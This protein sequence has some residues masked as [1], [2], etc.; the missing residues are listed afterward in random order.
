MKAPPGTKPLAILLAAAI[1]GA[2]A[3]R[4]FADRLPPVP[5][6]PLR[7]G[8]EPNP[9]FQIRTQQGFSGLVVDTV[10]EAARR[11]GLHLEWVDT[12]TN[13]EESFQRGLV[14]LWPSM[15][16]TV[17]QRKKGYLSAPW[18]LASHILMTTAGSRPL[19]SGFSGRI[20]VFK[21]PVHTHLVHERFPDA[22]VF[23]FPD[24][25][26]VVKAVCTGR[27]AAGLLEKRAA[28]TALLSAPAECASKNL[29]IHSLPELAVKSCLASTFE[30]AGAAA[31]LRREIGN[32][33][34][35]GS[36]GFTMAR[37]SFYGL[38]D[39]W[40]TFD[41]MQATERFRWMAWGSAAFAVA[42]C[43]ALWQTLLLRQRRRSERELRE[44][45][46]RFRAIFQQAGVGVAQVNLDG[47]VELAND[48]YCAVVGHG[49]GTLLGKGTRE[50]TVREDL[51]E[52]LAM[53][54]K[55]LSG[56]IQSFSTQKRYEREDGTLVWAELCKSL[57]RNLDG[58]PKHFIAVVQDI[59]ERKQAEAA[60]KESEERFRNMA[61][62]AP[63]L[64]W[65]AAP[66]QQRTFF[67]KRWLEFTG[68]PMEEDLGEG[69]TAL[70]HPD[71]LA[72]YLA[73]YASSFTTHRDFQMEYRLRRADGEYRFMLVHGVARLSKDG[74]FAG[75]IGSCIDITD[76]KSN[77]ER[78]LAT[79]KLESLGVL[80]AGVAH[81]FNNLLG[82]IV[83]RSECATGEL[84][85][86]SAAADD[87]EQIRV[88]AL[89]AAEI[90]SQMMT[91]AGQ[92]NAPL[93]PIDLSNLVTETLA[94]LRVSIAKGAVLKTELATNLPRV[95]ANSAE[96][97]QVVM[98]LIINAS[99]A[100]EGKPG[101]ISIAT[102]AASSDAG[103]AGAVRLRVEDTGC[104]MTD[105]VKTRIFDPFFTTRFAGRGLGLAAVQG[106]VRR[107]G[108]W[109]DVESEPGRG[110][111]FTVEL[112][113]GTGQ[114]D[115]STQPA[116]P[117]ASA[118]PA[119]SAVLFVDDEDA[120][121]T[122]V[123][124]VLRR[125]GFEVIEAADGASAIEILR[126]NQAAIGRI[127]LD[128]TL[129]GISGPE[130]FDELR[131][132][133][134]DVRIIV[135]TAYSQETVLAT[136]PGRNL[137]DF[138]R[139]PYRTHELVKLLE[140]TTINHTEPH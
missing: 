36:L 98:N 19:E 64:I 131:R 38:D 17:E 55:L 75:Y 59:T 110:S 31:R 115:G 54:P 81:D 41:L 138:I 78:H 69:W 7:I 49:R 65:V 1:A 111:R 6:R 35:D 95:D 40:A 94:L 91:F 43:I 123:S 127:V 13:S 30:A 121:R 97:R 3:Y 53:M 10:N 12:G 132:M 84:A 102:Y 24:A 80:A 29:R 2:A 129:P 73:T 58:E 68:R 34:R 67:N 83:A 85:P 28:T 79:Q 133:S 134:P 50:M 76:L 101:C 135:S 112:P 139:K 103:S 37:Y 71:D 70:I 47:R 118:V 48:R 126:S 20:A 99:E 108:G 61:D 18:I 90:V 107:H 27:A 124:R 8:F 113:C 117:E 62:S 66:D 44:S 26:D 42:L 93:N 120:L 122:V 16:D 140:Q 21:M 63:V 4:L 11:A 25:R 46:E 130:L 45:E 74:V 72:W 119:P 60:L 14:D 128:V 39:A 51:K 106:I 104:G 77:Y 22:Q 96:I 57:V 137:W 9:P 89:R 32:M 114:A 82:A 92:E 88:T 87:I 56:E 100:L 116:E 125:R 33:Y 86:N 105:A 5:E 136:F 109:I 52:Q 15:V 23:D